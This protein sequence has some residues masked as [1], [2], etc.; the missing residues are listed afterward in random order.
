[1]FYFVIARITFVA[2]PDRQYDNK[3]IT[4]T[5]GPE[6]LCF[7]KSCSDGEFQKVLIRKNESALIREMINDTNVL[8]MS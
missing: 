2:Y 3:Y 1:M 8:E 6:D 4:V 7:V 5:G